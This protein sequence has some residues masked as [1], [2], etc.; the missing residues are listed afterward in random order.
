[1]NLNNLPPVLPPNPLPGDSSAA[2]FWHKRSMAALPRW[3]R[4]M[5][6]R[7]MRIT[8]P[9]NHFR[10]RKITGFGF[11]L[12]QFI[13]GQLSTGCASPQFGKLI[14]TAFFE[15]FLSPPEILL[16]S[17][18]RPRLVYA[19]AGRGDIFAIQ[20]FRKWTPLPTMLF[21]SVVIAFEHQRTSVVVH[22]RC[23]VVMHIAVA[24][25]KM[26]TACLCSSMAS[27]WRLSDV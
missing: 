7:R 3:L 21:C 10:C 9:E 2:L 8:L 1:M 5:L 27:S 22:R 16:A 12:R 11:Q 20:R 14:A 4:R 6:L 25:L 26:A 18:A 19:A 13:R 17:A 24:F 15:V 23:H